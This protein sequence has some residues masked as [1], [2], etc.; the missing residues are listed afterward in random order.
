MLVPIL[1]TFRA[2]LGALGKT[3]CKMRT[4][5]FYC[6]RL[7]P[8]ST[9]RLYSPDFHSSS[10]DE[11]ELK[12]DIIAEVSGSH[13]EGIKKRGF[14]LDDI[15]QHVK[16]DGVK[17]LK[18]VEDGK[19]LQ[20]TWEDGHVSRFYSM[21]LRHNCHCGVCLPHTSTV[22]VNFSKI[23]ENIKVTSAKMDG[24]NVIVIGWTGETGE[25][26]YHE[27]PLLTK[28]LRYHCYS[29]AADKQRREQRA[30]R[31]YDDKTIPELEYK[32]VISSDEALYKWLLALSERGICLIKNVPSEKEHVLK[33]AERIAPVQHTI[34][35]NTFEVET[36][37]D[38]IPENAAH[39]RIG[40]DL[41]MDQ[42][43]Y[44]SPPGL[45]LLHCVK[46][47]ECI[48]GG[49]NFFVDM[50]EV[51]QKF[52]EEEPEL[53]YTLTRIPSTANTVDYKRARPAHVRIQRPLIT[54]NHKDEIVSVLWQPMLIA[55]L[56]VPEKDVEAFY[57]AYGK[58]Y[59]LVHTYKSMYVHRLR[60]GDMISF[61]NRR[62]SHGRRAYTDNGHRLLQ[63][64]YI[65]ASEFQSKV[66]MF[67]N[68]YGGGK[69]PVRNGAIDWQ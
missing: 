8:L 26:K 33:A 18:I 30:M 63:G 10:T 21:W 49:E 25:E 57:K 62:I 60:P 35:G 34:Y 52:K 50:H 68:K 24:D 19:H 6:R 16:G 1:C 3:C 20:I 55:P 4:I 31:F 61:N 15:Y 67:H 28:F 58:F 32:D 13:L 54:I 43:H 64:C 46:F 2:K 36:S 53:F 37:P 56:Q 23:D 66:Q 12:V 40:L 51:A 29:D 69:W 65:N 5:I 27:G 14:Y 59:S 22:L 7:T 45:Q 17:D 39:T 9:P 38:P 44:E 42:I 48:Q 47:D 11:K 41:H